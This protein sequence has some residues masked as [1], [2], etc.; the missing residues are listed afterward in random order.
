MPTSDLSEYFKVLPELLQGAK[1]T[2]CITLIVMT[3]ST[4]AG[5]LVALGRLSPWRLI[6]IP[7]VM[8]VEFVRGTP[9]LVHLYYIFFVLPFIGLTFPAIIAGIIGLSFGYTAYLSE[10][11]RAAILSVPKVQLEAANALGLSYYKTTR[12]VVLPQARRVALPSTTNYLL[13]LFK[14]TSLLSLIT[15]QELMFRGM[16]LGSLTFQYFV[17]FTDIAIIYFVIC[18]PWAYLASR[19]ERRLHAE[20]TPVSYESSGEQLDSQALHA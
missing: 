8:Y 11:F 6:R 13:G 5:L 10:V 17:I 15:I 1:W 18:Y 19:L 7:L 9:M 20:E 3:I 2:I 16:V 4:F 12:L 14:D